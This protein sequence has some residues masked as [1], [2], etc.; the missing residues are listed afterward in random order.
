MLTSVYTKA[1]RDR[2][3]G[4]LIGTGA[5]VLTAMGGIAIYA[6]L[7][8]TITTLWEG[9]PEAFL[10][11]AGIVPSAGITGIVLGEM[12]ALIAPLVLAGLAISI[13]TS[14][15]AG[16]ER[17]GTLG[18]LLA[19]PRSRTAVLLSK[20][21]ALVTLIALG[22]LITWGGLE[23]AMTVVGSSTKDLF[24]GGAV[25]HVMALSLFFGSL[26]LFLGSW[27]GNASASSGTSIGILIVSLLGAGL[28]PLIGGWEELARVF[29]WYYMSHS[30]P[31]INGTDW[32]HVA[33]LL[34]A[35]GALT[36]GAVAVVKRRDLKVGERADSFLDRIRGNPRVAKI[37]DRI[38]G[39]AQVANIGIKTLSDSQGSAVIGAA[40]IFYLALIIGPMY[41]AISD[42]L[43][44]LADVFPDVILAMVG[45]A[46][47]STAAGWYWA[48]M[49][50]MV[51]PGAIIAVTAMM[52][53]RALAGEERSRTMDLLLA[54]PVQRSRVVIEKGLAIVGIALLL[55]VATFL[56]TAGGS[57]LGGLDMSYGNI[58]AASVQSVALGALFGMVALVGSAASG[59]PRV[60]IYTATGVALVTWVINSFFPLSESLAD[61]VRISPFHYFQVN[62]PLING[63][64]WG[65]VGILVAASAVLLLI[66]VL[67]FQR[68][69][70]RG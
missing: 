29:P 39:Q 64:S 54:N 21:G 43:V 30:Q 52:G 2:T 5:V 12:V 28:L 3:I 66:S 6:D 32:A 47:M 62:Q 45:Y 57:L 18:V 35:V 49:F 19:N 51:V 69:D 41:N 58:A 23:L 65:N 60:A 37:M 14:A 59:K 48:E 27:T 36:I 42:A 31:L 44:E 38:S 22:G 8:D 67:L 70:V 26:A 68:R 25:I 40:A 50:S 63:I 55:G 15:I 46:D 61:W 17:D 13:G 1:I 33:I 11:I 34:S 9:M 4:I 24:V 16:E 53:V 56:G 10:A 20:A 7:P